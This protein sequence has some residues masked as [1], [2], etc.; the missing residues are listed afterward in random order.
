MTELPK[1]ADARRNRAL[2]LAA[3]EEAFAAEG[4]AVPLD[5]IARRAGVGAGTV[6]RHFP[7]KEALFEAVLQSRIDNLVGDAEARLEATDPGRAFFGLMS[8][9]ID[10]GIAKKDLVD[11]LVGSGR[12][13]TATRAGKD[14]LRKV[15]GRL[16]RR[17]QQAGDVRKDVSIADAMA[18]MSGIVLAAHHAGGDRRLAKRLFELV[19]DGMRP[20]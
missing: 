18:A 6:Y 10:D 14:Q 13:G 15:G 17:A 1:R 9:M 19:R 4:V 8:R 16:L 11:A 20:R 12:G 5:D 7:T 3:A 2:I